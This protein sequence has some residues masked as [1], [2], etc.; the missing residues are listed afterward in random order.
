MNS[1]AVLVVVL[2]LAM[3]ILVGNTLIAVAFLRGRKN[4]SKSFRG[5]ENKALDELHRRVQGLSRK[6]K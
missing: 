2:I 4:K 5:A 3:V 1:T 6:S